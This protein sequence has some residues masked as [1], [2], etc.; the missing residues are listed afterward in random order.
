M[1]SAIFCACAV[2]IGKGPTGGVTFQ[3]S[4]YGGI[5]RPFRSNI[6]FT[7]S[8]LPNGV[9][10]SAKRNTVP[11]SVNPIPFALISV[12][13]EHMSELFA[14]ISHLHVHATSYVFP[15]SDTVQK[16]IQLADP[17][18]SVRI[19]SSSSTSTL[20]T[21]F[22][23]RGAQ[24]RTLSI[25]GTFLDF[26]NPCI[27][28]TELKITGQLPAI[29]EAL[30]EVGCGI[31]TL[32]VSSL[33]R[34]SDLQSIRA[35]CP[36]ISSLVL[37]VV[38]NLYG[39]LA[40]LIASYGENIL[41]ANLNRFNDGQAR[42]VAESCPNIKVTINALDILVIETLSGRVIYHEATSGFANTEAMSFSSD[43][44]GSV[45]LLRK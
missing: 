43:I 32:H 41:Y 27:N 33:F 19:N 12:Q 9:V 23:A 21:L 44:C 30:S 3:M 5:S 40:H 20:Q 45:F 34:L 14:A 26:A 7:Q 25:P 13:P 29:E 2:S 15:S 39:N 24:L 36:N 35:H 4:I 28:L 22:A 31:R 1:C 10:A 17:L 11:V 37:K 8:A 16:L 6:F 42:F 18:T 38:K